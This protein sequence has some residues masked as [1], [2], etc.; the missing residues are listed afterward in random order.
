MATNKLYN[1]KIT[2]L[3]KQ[4]YN[5]VIF[6]KNVKKCHKYFINYIDFLCFLQYNKCVLNITETRSLGR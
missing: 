4:N 3:L 6:T 1:D 5:Y 2:N